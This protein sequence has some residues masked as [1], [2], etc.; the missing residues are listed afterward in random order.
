MKHYLKFFMLF[1]TAISFSQ[2]GHLM[3]GVGAVN[4]SMG[5]AATAQP[6]DVSGA[7]QWNP[8]TLSTFDGSI[9]KFD[10]GMFKGTPTLY[11]SLPAGM[12]G[13]GS[14]AVS[15]Q[16]DSDLGYAPMPALAFAWGKAE[17][18]HKFGV[19]AFGISGFGVDFPEETN[20]PLAGSNF[21]PT[22]NSNPILYPQ[23]AM[24]FGHMESSYMLM[25]VGF[26]WSY[27]V[28]EKLSI[29]VQPTINYESLEISPNPLANPSMTAGYP[30]S[31]NASA[32]GYG[33][34]VGVFYDTQEGFKFGASYK[35]PQY[36][37]EFEFNNTYLDDSEG[38]NNFTMDYPAI[39]SVGLG[40]SKSNFDLAIDYRR[41]DYDGTEGFEKTGWS[42]TA[43]IQGF[44]WEDMDVVS[45]G[46]QYK[47]IDKLP[48]R[49]GYT[50]SSNPIK[51]ELAMFSVPATA[52]IANAFQFGFSY[53][54]SESF[55]LDGVYHYGT[56][57]GKTSGKMLNPGMIGSDN[58]LGEMPGSE[59]A[60][61]MKTSMFQIGVSYIFGK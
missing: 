45:V 19:S 2:V 57:D 60:Y 15:G 59:V 58:P 36:F 13:P 11:S 52:I 6:L 5:G 42:P 9:L 7:M 54:V 43:S 44:G 47:G 14:P 40:Y 21:D 18:K 53:E 20:S 35:S 28:S 26:T 3:Q 46:L 8:A 51:D 39:Y 30:K 27:Q 41:V 10:I 56:S 29:G 34:Q 25:Q 16:A 32:I 24:G 37:G 55:K 4:M 48:L 61:D 1:V 17:S 23:Q 50:Y 31:D 38:T 12:M 33:G 49:V 22:G